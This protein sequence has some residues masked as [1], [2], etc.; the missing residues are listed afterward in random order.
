M[1]QPV[2]TRNVPDLS[3]PRRRELELVVERFKFVH[4]VLT[5]DC[6]EK[7]GVGERRVLRKKWTIQIS[8]DHIVRNGALAAGGPIVSTAAKN[9]AQG[10]LPPGVCFEQTDSRYCGPLG[11]QEPTAK[12][13]RGSA[14]FRCYLSSKDFLTQFGS[15]L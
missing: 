5:S 7:K 14:T 6:G 15:L 1:T 12:K 2:E 4:S 8:A 9:P 10:L 3:N 13:P 11:G